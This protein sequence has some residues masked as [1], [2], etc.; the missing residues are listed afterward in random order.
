MQRIISFLCISLFLISCSKEKT[1]GFVV[2]GNLDNASNNSLVTLIRSEGRE[3]IILD[4]TRITENTF[5]LN[6]KVENPDMY[7][8][9]IDG[10]QGSLPFI[11]ENET[12]DLTIY[13]DSIFTSTIKGGKENNYFNE[14]QDYIKK[15]RFKNN[16]LTEQFKTA[17]QEQDTSKIS[18]LRTEYEGLMKENEANDLDFM[19]K[20]KDAILS[21]LI[22][23]RALMTKKLEFIK[24]KELFTNF[25]ETV[26]N[27]R[28]GKAIAVHIEA[29]ENTAIGSI[30]PNF[31]GPNPEGKTIALNDIKGKIT[32]IDFWAAWCGPCRKENPNV[33]KVYEKYHAKGLEIIGVS[34]DGT[35][36][37]KDAK[38]AWIDAI[39]KDN[40]TW[41]HVS[42]LQ[43]FNDPIAKQ[44][45][46]NSIPATYLIDAE[47]KIIA[48]NLRGPALENKIAELLN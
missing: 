33:V 48:K 11:I 12:I 40:L 32:I 16:K 42:N 36:K 41:H 15:L 13:T 9:T 4:S 28:A 35:P 37:Q 10:V 7:F 18:S 34:L 39:K 26:K 27:T 6:G 8:L 21:A 24:G 45:S 25:D 31:S 17:Q 46:I 29:N 47:G 43:Y 30:A 3:T 14:Y 20:N 19:Q 23:E 1:D 22:L 44:F 2:N 38:Q 5:T